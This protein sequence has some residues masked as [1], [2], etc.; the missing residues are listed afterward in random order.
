VAEVDLD[1]AEVLA[2]LQ[3]MRGIGVAQGSGVMKVPQ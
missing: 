1:L 3:Q 2:L